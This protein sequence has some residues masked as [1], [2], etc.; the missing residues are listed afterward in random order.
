MPPTFHSGLQKCLMT[1]D[2][3]LQWEEQSLL[4]VLAPE[5]SHYFITNHLSL[6]RKSLRVPSSQRVKFDTYIGHVRLPCK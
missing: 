6:H 5:D 3:F 1:A 4:S 2:I